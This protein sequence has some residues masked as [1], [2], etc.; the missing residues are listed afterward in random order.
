MDNGQNMIAPRS[1]N[2]WERMDSIQF[3]VHKFKR[4]NRF[5][6]LGSLNTDDNMTS[7]EIKERI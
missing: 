4:V 5:K 6:Y 1:R 7:E 3:G 2:M